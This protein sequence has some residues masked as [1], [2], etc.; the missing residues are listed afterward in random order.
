MGEDQ[1]MRSFKDVLKGDIKSVFLNFSEFGEEHKINGETVLIIIDENELT[2]REKRTRHDMDVKL[3][4]KQ[5]LFYIAAEDFGP[6]PSPGRVLELD[7]KEYEITDANN[8]DGIYS[9]SLEATRS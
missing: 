2:E 1:R 8:E 9:I 6:L 3:H 4:K 5:L 7:G